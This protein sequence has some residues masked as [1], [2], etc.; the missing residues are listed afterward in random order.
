MELR[1]MRYAVSVARHGNFRHAA[2]HMHVSQSALSQQI[3]KLEEELGD[4]LFER[5]STGVT[6]TEPG[7]R[8]IRKA[9]SVLELAEEAKSSAQSDP[10]SPTGTLRIGLLPTIHSDVIYHLLDDIKD[11]DRD[12]KIEIRE[13]QPE[14]LLDQLKLGNLDHLIVTDPVEESEF[15]VH[16]LGEEQFRLAVP[17]SWAPADRS[18]LSWQDLSDYHMLALEEGHSYRKELFT[19]FDETD[20]NPDLTYRGNCLH[21]LLELVEK[22]TGYTIIPELFTNYCSTRSI[23]VHDFQDQSPSRNILLVQRQASHRS[24]LDEWFIETVTEWFTERLP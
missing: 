17:D 10:D 6:L 7:E 24:T 15:S 19:F 3:K 21:T 20:S 22:K 5:Q 14:Y 2:E 4:P 13:G 23:S 18:E 9:Q 12:V 11:N 8:F 16:N 1:Q